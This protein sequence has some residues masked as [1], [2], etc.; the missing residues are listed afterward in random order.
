M[1]LSP[2]HDKSFLTANL[3]ENTLEVEAFHLTWSSLCNC[4]N[5]RLEAASKSL[6]SQWPLVLLLR[7]WKKLVGIVLLFVN[8]IVTAPAPAACPLFNLHPFII[9]HFLSP[10][11]NFITFSCK[12]SIQIIILNKILHFSTFLAIKYCSFLTSPWIFIVPFLLFANFFYVWI[13]NLGPWP[14]LWITCIF[15]PPPLKCQT[16][17]RLF[18]II[19]FTN[20]CLSSAFLKKGQLCNFIIPSI[21]FR[22][23]PGRRCNL[24]K[25]QGLICWLSKPQGWQT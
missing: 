4:C 15:L 14:F 12:D 8:S 19:R 7:S 13:E 22:Q 24:A 21:V 2:Q 3:T 23:W 6:F 11:Y 20:F 5:R 17:R 10:Y 18:A 1:L 16:D 9:G 25:L